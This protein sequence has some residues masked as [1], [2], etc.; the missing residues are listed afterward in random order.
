MNLLNLFLR[1]DN[2]FL[3]LCS[4]VGRGKEKQKETP[5]QDRIKYVGFLNVFVHHMYF[6]HYIKY[7]LVFVVG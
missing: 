1:S 3:S 5:N 6:F 7:G 4:V 2:S